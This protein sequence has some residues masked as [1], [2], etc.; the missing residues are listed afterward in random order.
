MMC[1]RTRLL[2]Y[3]RLMRVRLILLPL[4]SR[5]GADVPEF[6]EAK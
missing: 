1:K 5:L 4:L 3:A 6:T 2:F